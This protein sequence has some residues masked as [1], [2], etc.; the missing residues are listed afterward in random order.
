MGD[1]V[2]VGNAYEPPGRPAN[3]RVSESEVLRRIEAVR[4]D[5][6]FVSRAERLLERDRAL[7]E[8]LGD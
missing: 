5:D 4:E 2:R 7:L 3:R 6:S 1:T 8:R